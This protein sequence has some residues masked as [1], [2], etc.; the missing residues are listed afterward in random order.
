MRF[1]DR[2]ACQMLRRVDNK[3]T[4]SNGKDKDCSRD[5]RDTTTMTTKKKMVMTKSDKGDEKLNLER[6]PRGVDK[7][8]AMDE[9]DCMKDRKGGGGDKRLPKERDADTM[10]MKIKRKMKRKEGEW[11]TESVC[12]QHLV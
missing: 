6:D 11:M 10:K 5:C 4:D 8:D 1:W 12:S 3:M 2:L 7:R 9:E